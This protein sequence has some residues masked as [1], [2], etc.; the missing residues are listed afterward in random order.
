MTNTPT[1]MPRQDL[2]DRLRWLADEW[3]VASPELQ[4]KL[5]EAF[6]RGLAHTPEEEEND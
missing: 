2:A 1:P 4:T 3:R 6:K 5:E